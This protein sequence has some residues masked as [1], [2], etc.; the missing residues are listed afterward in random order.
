MLKMITE[1]GMSNRLGP[2]TF[3]GGGDEVFLGKEI[4][5]GPHYSDNIAAAIDEETHSIITSGY[6]KAKKILEENKKTP[7]RLSKSIPVDIIYLTA[8]VEIIRF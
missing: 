1:Y 4:A 5:S 7:Y 3:K 2:V 8:L 6:E